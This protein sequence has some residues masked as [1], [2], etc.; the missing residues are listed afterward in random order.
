MQACVSG[1]SKEGIGGDALGLEWALMQ[2]GAAS[3]LSGNWNIDASWS[4]N[5]CVLFY[6]FWLLEQQP[7]AQALRNAMLQLMNAG[8]PNTPPPPYYWAC[9]SLSG[10]WR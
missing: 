4:A 7:R 3:I 5:C 8:L 10:D 1:L 9:L 6:R 2:Q